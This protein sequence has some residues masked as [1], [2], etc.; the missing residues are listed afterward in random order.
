V[1]C[2]NTLSIIKDTNVS[3]SLQTNFFISRHIIFD[4]ACFP[5]KN[6][7]F[8]TH[9][10]YVFSFFPP[11]QLVV[12]QPSTSIIP[13]QHISTSSTPQLTTLLIPASSKPLPATPTP[14]LHV[15][16]RRRHPPA[17]ILSLPLF[18]PITTHSMLTRLKTATTSLLP[19]VLI[20]TNHPTPH[21]DLDATSYTQASKFEHWRVVMAQEL[22]ALARNSTWS[23]V[24]VSEASNICGL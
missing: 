21:F 7:H 24:S 20:S 13:F 19:K 8:S 23:L 1:F 4:E 22:N 17:S 15:Y 6:Q 14:C 5:F 3:A 18:A 11:S 16:Q 2:L 9:S 10:S 12:L